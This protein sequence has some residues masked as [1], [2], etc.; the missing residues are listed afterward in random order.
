MPD[1]G[2]NLDETFCVDKLDVMIENFDQRFKELDSDKANHKNL[3]LIDPFAVDPGKTDF[4]FQELIDLQ[5]SAV[6]KPRYE[7]LP[8]IH[9]KILHGGRFCSRAQAQSECGTNKKTFTNI[10]MKSKKKRSSQQFDTDF[11]MN[12]GCI[13]ITDHYFV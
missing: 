11:G 4:A 12:F 5:N 9:C 13:R 1:P 3:L 10:R 8:M 2:N 6:L 7:K